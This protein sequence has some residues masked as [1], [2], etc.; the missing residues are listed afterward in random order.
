[1]IVDNRTNIKSL[2]FFIFKCKFKILN[3]RSFELLMSKLLME[4]MENEI[5]L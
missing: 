4:Y 2:F 1:M 3:T 5:N